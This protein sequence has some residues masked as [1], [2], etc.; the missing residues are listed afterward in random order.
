MNVSQ[1]LAA[2]ES[3]FWFLHFMN[4]ADMTAFTG[5]R[6]SSNKIVSIF[7]KKGSSGKYEYYIKH[8]SVRNEIFRS[9]MSYL[10]HRVRNQSLF[11]CVRRIKTLKW[12]VNLNNANSQLPWKYTPVLLK[13]NCH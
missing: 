8:L 5:L 4:R 7:R 10:P 11:K 12:F 13:I 2:S 9:E 1:H 6:I 3:V